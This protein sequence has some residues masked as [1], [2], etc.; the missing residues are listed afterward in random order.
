MEGQVGGNSEL[1]NRRFLAIPS[2]CRILASKLQI[3]HAKN[4]QW[5]LDPASTPEFPKGENLTSMLAQV[6]LIY[7]WK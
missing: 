5:Q 2:K 7:L 4:Y 6:S 1:V 3:I